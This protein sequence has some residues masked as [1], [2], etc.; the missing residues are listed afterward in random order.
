[1]QPAARKLA[2]NIRNRLCLLREERNLSQTDLEKPTGMVRFHISRVENGHAVP[3][4]E[5]LER[6]AAAL[7]VPLYR[8]FYDPEGAQGP[9]PLFPEALAADKTPYERRLHRL[10]HKMDDS[11]RQVLLDLARKLASK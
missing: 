11:G 3:K 8:L 10:V 6:M 4:L 9:L 2:L 1:L 5:T 7:G